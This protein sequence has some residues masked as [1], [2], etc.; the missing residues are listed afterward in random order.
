MRRLDGES[1]ALPFK[2]VTPAGVARLTVVFTGKLQDKDVDGLF[3]RLEPNQPNQPGA[4]GQGNTPGARYAMT[5]FEST[6]ARL[7]FPAF[8]EPGW[9]LPWT[10]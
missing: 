2:Q 8:D 9:K 1:L 5:Q 6:G 4:P 7:A 10:L 3:R